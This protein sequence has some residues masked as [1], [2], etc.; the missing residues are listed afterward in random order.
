MRVG[1]C[2][3]C[4]D[5]LHE[6]HLHFLEQASMHCDYL[7]VAVNN[8]RSVRE[9]KG[10]MRP[11]EPLEVRLANLRAYTSAYVDAII[12]FDGR[13]VPLIGQILPD[14][15][16]RGDDQSDEGHTLRPIVRIERL[17]GYSTSLQLAMAKAKTSA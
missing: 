15:I 5:L 13:P 11:I 3:G 14:V 6:G 1:F 2:N 9:L 17:P 10:D 12:P 7:I 16:I 8:D 4:Y